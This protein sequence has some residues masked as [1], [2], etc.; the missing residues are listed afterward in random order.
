MQ[1]DSIVSAPVHQA[2][3]IL[4]YYKNNSHSIVAY[5]NYS[6]VYQSGLWNVHLSDTNE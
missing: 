6:F 2:K 4:L 1:I 5:F 3:F